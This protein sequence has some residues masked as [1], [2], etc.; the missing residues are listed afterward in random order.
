MCPGLTFCP[1][2][3]PLLMSTQLL[4]GML[5][6]VEAKHILDISLC[7]YM[8]VRSCVRVHLYAHPTRDRTMQAVFIKT[9]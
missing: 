1:L 2:T 3:E 4:W 5:P 7:V 8:S 9:S 6:Y